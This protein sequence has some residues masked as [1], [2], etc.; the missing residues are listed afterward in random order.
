[1]KKLLLLIFLTF[2]LRKRLTVLASGKKS[3]KPSVLRAVWVQTLRVEF[4]AAPLRGRTAAENS[5][6]VPFTRG[7]GSGECSANRMCRPNVMGSGVCWSR[8]GYLLQEHRLWTPSHH[9]RQSFQ[10]KA[11]ITRKDQLTSLIWSVSF[12]R[13]C[14]KC[15]PRD[16]KQKR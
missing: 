13:S 2:F 9:T 7:W 15:L 3:H 12:L 1:M 4:H 14:P 16:A 5:P 6:G 10:S 11:F 8:W